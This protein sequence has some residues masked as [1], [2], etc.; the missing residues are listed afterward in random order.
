MPLL[1]AGRAGPG[2]VYLINTVFISVMYFCTVILLY[3]YIFINFNIDILP[4]LA[5]SINK[6]FEIFQI[7]Q[8]IFETFIKYF[9]KTKYFQIFQIFPGPETFFKYFLKHLKHLNISNI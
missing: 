3:Y 1:P 6:L 9:N 2:T 8:E 5:E 7:F 4:C